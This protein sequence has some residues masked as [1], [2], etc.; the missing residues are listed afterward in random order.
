MTMYEI[1]KIKDRIDTALQEIDKQSNLKVI[2]YNRQNECYPF[3]IQKDTQLYNI[4]QV[5]DSANVIDK[6][7]VDDLFKKLNFTK[8]NGYTFEIN[9]FNNI[10]SRLK[11]I[12]VGICV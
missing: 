12:I 9:D 4:M 8:V 6:C 11:Q 10:D 7:N 5:L 2:V 1:F 3:L